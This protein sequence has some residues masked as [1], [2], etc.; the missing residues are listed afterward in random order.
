MKLAVA[1]L[2][3]PVVAFAQQPHEQ[4]IQRAIIQLDQRSAEFARGVAA[5]PL[6]PRVGQPLNPDPEIARQLRPYERMR[7]A[8]AGAVVVLQLPPPVVQKKFEKPLPLPG[9]P[10][11]GVDPVTNPSVPN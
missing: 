7:E 8:E 1:L 3:I 2:A 9:G 6:D 4:E 11:A 5:A 10:R